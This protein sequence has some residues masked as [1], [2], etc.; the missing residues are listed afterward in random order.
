[1]WSDGRRGETKPYPLCLWGLEMDR[2]MLWSKE[3]EEEE[4]EERVEVVGLV[5]RYVNVRMWA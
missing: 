1:V 5:A 3:E 4:E 2:G